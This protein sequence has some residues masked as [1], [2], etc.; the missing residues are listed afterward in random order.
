MTPDRA[1]AAP[2]EESGSHTPPLCR[3]AGAPAAATPGDVP[4]EAGTSYETYDPGRKV[5]PP[6][7]ETC[8]KCFGRNHEEGINAG[9]KGGCGQ[10]VDIVHTPFGRTNS[11]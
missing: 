10:G 11:R 4:A 6:A 1:L 9:P 2:E 7:T 3:R 8:M 5:M